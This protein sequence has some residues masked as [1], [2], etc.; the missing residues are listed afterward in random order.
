VTDIGEK[1][2]YDCG[3]MKDVM[4]GARV[5]RIDRDAFAGCTNL[6]AFTV[7]PGNETFFD[8]SGL[9]LL[10]NSIAIVAVPGGLTDVTIPD[11]VESIG[12]DEFAGCYN[13]KHV[14][15]S[16]SVTEIALDTFADCPLES[17]TIAP[18]NPRYFVEDGCLCDR[19]TGERYL[20]REN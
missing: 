10:S 17:L 1:A 14:T 9:L 2:F 13:L 18:G 16:A 7:S 3:S 12:H 20:I 15:I 6:T 4:I 5:A 8:E 11:G 19:E